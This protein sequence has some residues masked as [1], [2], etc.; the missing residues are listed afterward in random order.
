MS[1]IQKQEQFINLVQDKLSSNERKWLEQKTS[2]LSKPETIDKF[3]LFFSLASRFI[4]KE[5]PKWELK[6]IVEME[7]IYPGFSKSYWTKQHMARVILMI[8][9]DVSKNKRILESFFEAAEMEEL[10]AFF[11]GL[12]LLENAEEF[13]NM[14]E[15][16]IRTNM[17]NVFDSFSSG[18]PFAKRHLKEWAWNQ[19]VLKAL[20]LEHPLYTIQ[21]ID[22]GKN[23]K[24]ADMLQDYVKERW[25]AN[26][27]VSPEIWRM[28]E[29]FLRQDI[30]VLLLGRDFEGVEEQVIDHL[31]TGNNK[32]KNDDF[33]DTIG[34][35]I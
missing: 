31:L 27:S 10:I 13:T 7:Q 32:A 29:G 34:K 12:Y 20:F 18:N 6:E 23:K 21:D 28:I 3:A 15:E 30:K 16:G 25:S 35:L 24:L 5:V 33:W 2:I 17:V 1:T 14:V 11:K 22:D 9:L 19:L 26:R 8:S 4:T